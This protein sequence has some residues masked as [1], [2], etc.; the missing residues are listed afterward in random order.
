MTWL[1]TKT[2][3]PRRAE[4]MFGPPEWQWASTADVGWWVRA[5]WQSALLDARGLRL[6]EWKD[7]GLL[8]VVKKGPHRVVY[9]VDLPEGPVYVKHFLVPNFRS[10]LRQW[11]RRGKGRNEGKRTRFLDAIGVPTITPIA[12]GE[13][14]KRKFLFEN[15][16]ITPAIP[17]AVP[18]D[19]FVERRL[20]SLPPPSRDRV[21][22]NLAEALGVLTARLHDA[23]FVHKDFHPGNILVRMGDDGRP[24]LAMIDLDA[25]RVCRRLGWADAQQNLALLNHYFWLRSGRA[26]RF[27]F[28]RSYLEARESTNP[29]PKAFSRGIEDA[30][31]AWAERL[32]RRW[33]RRCHKSNKYFRKYRGDEAWS[34]AS[35]ELDQKEIRALL[36]DPDEPFCRPDT[37]LIKRSRTT[38]VA[39]TTMTVK[40]HRVAVIYKRF[41]RKKWLDPLLTYFRPSRAWQ[42]WQAGQHLLSRAVPTPKNLAFIAR[43]RTFRQDP[44]FWYLPHETYLITR[45]AEP[46]VTLYDYV[47]RVLPG[48]DPA[49]RRERIVRVT[50]ALARLLRVLHERSLSDRDLKTSNILIV[51]D[52]DAESIRLELIDLGGVRLIHPLPLHRR[53]QNLS[54][55]YVSLAE[56]PGLTRT[57]ALRF[58]RAYLPWGLSPHNDWRGLWRA[59]TASSRLKQERNRRSGRKLS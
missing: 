7:Q 10:K 56:V 1:F 12:L 59:I 55:L 21:R 27:R 43:R 54:R 35:R 19:Q 14:R 45:K 46:S 39:E 31:R 53:V 41:N 23:G 2:P 42:A 4:K 51:G 16:L 30:T 3:G 24:A 18:L 52:P 34:V 58:L 20:P 17:D 11:V 29:D 36:L 33:G 49:D 40:G 37:I 5:D 44:L 26:D 47:R 50:L 28:L 6:D 8:T 57:D 38:T 25:L 22:Q 13:Q 32:W 48:L 9:R 15:Y